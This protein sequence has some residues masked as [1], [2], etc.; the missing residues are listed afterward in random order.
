MARAMQPF[1]FAWIEQ[2]GRS[3]TTV[4]SDVA[5]LYEQRCID[6][7]EEQEGE[8]PAQRRD[9]RQPG[10]FGKETRADTAQRGH[11][12][13]DVDRGYASIRRERHAAVA[14]ARPRHHRERHQ[15]DGAC[16]PGVK[17]G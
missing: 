16:R 1:P 11:D 5:R 8:N 3:F 10:G 4:H 7:G 17:G 12:C 2:K 14:E 13:E 9:M 6:S 15:H